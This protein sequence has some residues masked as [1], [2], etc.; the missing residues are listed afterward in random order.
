MLQTQIHFDLDQCRGG[1]G[2]KELHRVERKAGVP[3]TVNKGAL[4]GKKNK[5]RK[6][7]K[8]KKYS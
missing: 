4:A 3:L 2:R 7:K 8:K 6:K 1:T 5:H